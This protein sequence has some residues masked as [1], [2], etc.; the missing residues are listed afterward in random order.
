MLLNSVRACINAENFD[1]MQQLSNFA[2][3]KNIQSDVY[4]RMLIVNN[5]KLFLSKKPSSGKET[6]V[7]VSFDNILYTSDPEY[8]EKI[9]EML[10]HMWNN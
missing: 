1:V 4:M 5:E 7:M 3:L 2:H 10:K 8:G 9:G 6:E